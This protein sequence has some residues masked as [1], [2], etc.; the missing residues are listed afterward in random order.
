MCNGVKGILTFVYR[1]TLFTGSQGPPGLG[2]GP[3]HATVWPLQ[4]SK[5]TVGGL[6]LTTVARDVMSYASYQISGRWCIWCYI[7]IYIMYWQY[8]SGCNPVPGSPF[9]SPVAGDLSTLQPIEPPQSS[10]PSPC[11]A[12][13][14]FP[15]K[16]LGFEL[17]FALPCLN[18]SA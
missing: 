5:A 17:F 8:K 10:L 16:L 13:L 1:S 3:P 14:K 12:P 7:T 9:A 15:N 2:Y 18:R 11:Q 4:A 6:L